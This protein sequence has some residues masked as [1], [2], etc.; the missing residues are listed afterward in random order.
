MFFSFLSLQARKL[1]KLLPEIS[2]MLVQDQILN[3]LKTTGPT[4]PIK[5]GK[6]IK[7]DLIIASAH[8]ADLTSQG[9]VKISN[10]KVG[11]S[12]LYYLPGQE[13]QLY[14]FVSGNINPKDLDVLEQ[15]R[16]SKVL[17]ES[18]LELLPKVALRAQ[19]D[20]AIPLHVRFQGGVELFW[21]WYL[22]SDAETNQIIG[23]EIALLLLSNLP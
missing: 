10:L 18:E 15:L 4:L 3:L 8:L 5:V 6:N 13:D 14:N 1:Y 23:T 11:G 19:K 16:F 22:A 12:P 7:S 20:F 9:K 21:R 2:S 17:R